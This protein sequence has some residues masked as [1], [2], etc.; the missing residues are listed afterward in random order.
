[1][2]TIPSVSEEK[3]DIFLIPYSSTELTVD[4]KL[5]DWDKYFEY[6]FS[7][8]LTKFTQTP[9]H[10]LSE[11]YPADFDFSKVMLPKS[12]NKV[13]FRAFWN[14]ENL[15]CAIT[16]WDKH[17]FAEIPSKKGKPLTYLND[18]I[19]LYIDT[20][21][22]GSEKIDLNDYQF[23]V[24]I[25]NETTTFK[26][27]IREMLADT[28]AVPKDYGLH[29]L[30]K[31]AV[32]I[33]GT[34]NDDKLDTSY[35]IEMEIP[36]LSLGI[37]PD[38]NKKMRLDIGINDIDYSKSEARWFDD[39]ST[40]MWSFDWCG[41]SDFGYPVLWKKIQL[42]GGPSWFE[43]VS[44]K[45][46]ASWIWIY[47]VTVIIAVL[48]ISYLIYRAHKIR[49]LPLATDVDK[50]K[51]TASNTAKPLSHNEKILQKASQYI[52][53]NKTEQIHSEELAKYLG[54]SLRNLQRI[55]RE[56]LNS[57]PTNFITIVKLNLAAE[58]LKS[59]AGNVSDAAYEFGFSD[60]AYFSKLFKKHFEIS[61]R[62][63][64][65]KNSK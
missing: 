35:T 3:N 28:F 13:R 18:G 26:G 11:V 15:Y 16:V 31:T 61:P 33:Q 38:S 34:M 6:E 14:R 24:D 1:M 55:T 47:I 65:K 2:L 60:P 43:R 44:E 63:F 40:G 62:D 10:D 30:Y 7:D 64:I 23:I 46:H 9:L 12:R 53:D 56:E 59:K 52:V 54:L 41:Y 32:N 57:T 27:D 48:L 25:K 36:F 42:A 8:T 5:D 58:F 49:Q 39:L 21:N 19:E 29:I 20:G 17:L 45:Y 4:G 50:N 22:E 51:I 37:I